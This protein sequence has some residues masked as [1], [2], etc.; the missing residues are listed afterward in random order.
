MTIV[1]QCTK[2]TWQSLFLSII[3]YILQTDQIRGNLLYRLMVTNWETGPAPLWGPTMVPDPQHPGD[4]WVLECCYNK[5]FH[6]VGKEQNNLAQDTKSVWDEN[7][8]V[9]SQPQT[10]NQLCPLSIV[11]PLFSAS[12]ALTTLDSSNYPLVLNMEIFQ[13]KC[14]VWEGMT[15]KNS[16]LFG[17]LISQLM[18]L[19]RRKTERA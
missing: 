11:W 3:P 17:C 18:T 16:I 5:H 4:L 15:I 12:V 14:S 8:L 13:R 10:A 1:G 7:L 9:G 6:H 2:L 19:G